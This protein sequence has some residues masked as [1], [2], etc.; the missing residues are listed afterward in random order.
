[1]KK[2]LFS[3]LTGGMLAVSLIAFSGCEQKKPAPAPAPAT[4]PEQTTTGQAA[5]ATPA[6]QA[7]A[8]AK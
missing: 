1:M 7:A 6:G 2:Q 8:P 3:V 5:P 4:Q